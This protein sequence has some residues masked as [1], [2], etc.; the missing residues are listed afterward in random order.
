MAYMLN[1][2][3][4]RAAFA[5]ET[6]PV[7]GE[8]RAFEVIEIGQLHISSRR[9]AACDPFANPCPIAFAQAIPNGSHPV[10]LAV[11]RHRE[12]DERIAL[13]RVSFSNDDAT[14]WQMAM[15][16]LHQGKPLKAAEYFGYGVDAGTGCFMDPA[17]GLLLDG[18]SCDRIMEEMKKTYRP[19]RDWCDVRPSHEHPENVICFTAGE[20]DGRYPSFFGF[21]ADDRVCALVTDFLLLDSAQGATSWRERWWRA[22]WFGS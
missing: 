13:A 17:A 15:T 4:V 3:Q 19:T 8:P 7:F 5:G 12:G 2:N 6:L 16:S 9:I 21:A 1:D 11:A 20:G 10:S 18:D 14:R 22:L